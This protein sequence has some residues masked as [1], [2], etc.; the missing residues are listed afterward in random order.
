MLRTILTAALLVASLGATTAHAREPVLRD[1]FA[2]A[3]S[4][5]PH[6]NISPRHALGFSQYTGGAYSHSAA[7]GWNS[8]YWPMHSTQATMLA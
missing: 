5:W 4:G 2:N 6:T 1:D 8:R 3:R 7:H